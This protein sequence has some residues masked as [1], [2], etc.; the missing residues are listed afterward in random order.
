MG[1]G[2]NEMVDEELGYKSLSMR[3]SLV[4][5]QQSDEYLKEKR[6]GVKSQLLS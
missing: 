5:Y 1:Q 3:N 4:R 2:G 6:D